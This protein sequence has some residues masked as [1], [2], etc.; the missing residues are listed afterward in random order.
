MKK[1]Q[2]WKQFLKMAPSISTQYKVGK[3]FVPMQQ[4]ICLQ[5]SL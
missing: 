5:E 1:D 4:N 3:Y 2:M